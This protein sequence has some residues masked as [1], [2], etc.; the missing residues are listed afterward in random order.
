M[1]LMFMT[2]AR[3]CLL[4]SITVL[5]YA[6]VKRLVCHFKLPATAYL[7]HVSNRLDSVDSRWT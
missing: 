5:R 7:D 3:I 1:S 4:N 6:G 2:S